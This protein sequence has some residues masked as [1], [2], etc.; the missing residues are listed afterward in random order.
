MEACFTAGT[1]DGEFTG[2]DILNDDRGYCGQGVAQGGIV[3]TP[4]G[5]W[6]AVL[7]QDHGAAGRI[8]VLLPAEFKN[9]FPVFGENGKIPDGFA[10]SESSKKSVCEALTDSDDFKR[11]GPVS[12]IANGRKTVSETYDS[13]GFKSCWQI[14]HEPKLSCVS[15][16]AAGVLRSTARGF[17]KEIMPGSACWPA[18]TAWQ[19]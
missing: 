8:P 3:D 15:Q 2:G 11:R 17:G 4:D 19:R 14:N 12:D 6:Y 9:G 16:N 13:Y 7:F 10:V 18:A 1:L 5:K